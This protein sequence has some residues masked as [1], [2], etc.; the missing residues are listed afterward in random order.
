VQP[1][2]GGGIGDVYLAMDTRLGRRVA[3]KL[4]KGALAK[5][6]EVLSRF[7][8]EVILSAALESEH[9]VEV[10]DYGVA[11]GDHPFYVMEYLHGQPLSQLIGRSNRLSPELVIQIAI[12]ICA[13]LKV[14][15]EGVIL[16][17]DGEENTER[18]K[19]IHR[20]LKPANIFLVPTAIGA[21]VKV[22]DFGIAKKLHTTEQSNQT[23]L[24]Q[25][26]LGTFRYASP[27]Q[28]I[29]ARNL[30]ER[31]D[32][33]SLGMILYEMLTGTDPFG[34][35]ATPSRQ[36]EVAW[37]MAHDAGQPVPLRQRP[38][39]AH[40]PAELE[41]IVMRCLKRRASDRFASAKELMQALHAVSLTVRR[42]IPAAPP[43]SGARQ[44][45]AGQ[46]TAEQS[47]AGLEPTVSKPLMPVLDPTITRPLVPETTHSLNATAPDATIAQTLAP[48]TEQPPDLSRLPDKPVP[49]DGTIAQSSP[50]PA[51][52]ET[53]VQ[54]RT[55]AHTPPRDETIAQVP[56]PF[57]RRD[58][59]IAQVS[60]QPRRRDETIAQ[61]PIQLPRRDETIAQAPPPLIKRD[62][63]IVQSHHAKTARADE[64]QAQIPAW[65][66]NSRPDETMAQMSHALRGQLPL[67][68]VHLTPP[69][70]TPPHLTPPHLTPPHLTPPHLTSP[71]S[72]IDAAV[73]QQMRSVLRQPLLNSLVLLGAGFFVGLLMMVGVYVFLR[74]SQPQSP[75]SQSALPQES[76]DRFNDRFNV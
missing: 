62:E 29:N 44:S 53:I 67:P 59:T 18:I 24:T 72:A 21:L 15:H 31:A 2:G 30:D 54:V 45:V 28:L 63:T 10:L 68:S 22:L 55:P 69:H 71:V 8:R 76:S 75:Q 61:V 3:I 52:E 16:W 20:D 34:I 7:E 33:Y 56:P 66:N 64:T 73:N 47:T 14:A 5:S 65:N 35:D 39:C 37:A 32:L 1:L 11:A 51:K 12:Q 74:S 40:I 57:P 25:A 46:F 48:S 4:L 41:E 23:N 49:V 19:V 70:L 13:G 9:I 42:E 38:E 43:Q 26:F 17:R 27:E 50:Q 58:E 36:R 60:P 6:K